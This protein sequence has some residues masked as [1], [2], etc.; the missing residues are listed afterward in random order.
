VHVRVDSSSNV[1][2][3]MG[4]S[5]YGSLVLM[6][7]CGNFEEPHP[8]IDVVFPKLGFAKTVETGSQLRAVISEVM[9]LLNSR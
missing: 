9:D 2:V 4:R 7:V 5:I 6:E 3:N 8:T 1:T